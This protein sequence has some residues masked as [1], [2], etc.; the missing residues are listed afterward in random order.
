MLS[1]EDA[2]E[3]RV[4]GNRSTND[5]W[6]EAHRI[7]AQA[8]PAITEDEQRVAEKLSISSEE[9]SRSKYAAELTK[10]QLQQR[11]LK[12]GQLIENWLRKHDESAVV[13]AVWLK[14]FEGKYRVDVET[15][16]AVQNVF[17]REELID[18]VL[19]SGSHEAK[20]SLDRLLSLNLL[21]QE[22]ARA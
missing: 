1:A 17:V 6:L 7:P 20:L 22:A 9:Y 12:V 14:T 3:V 16:G 2:M 10:T 19:D 4:D 11:A 18:D 8:L 13:K 5:S 15:Y 21:A